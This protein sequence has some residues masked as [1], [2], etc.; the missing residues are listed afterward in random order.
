MNDDIRAMYYL[1]DYNQ[2]LVIGY[3]YD[4]VFEAELHVTLAMMPN[5][6]RVSRKYEF[7]EPIIYEFIKS[8]YED[9]NE[10]LSVVSGKPEL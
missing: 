7:K 9:F 10:F 2:L 3:S 5:F 6:M 4:A 8:N 1:T